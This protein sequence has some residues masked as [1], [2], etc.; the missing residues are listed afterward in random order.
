[1]EIILETLDYIQIDGHHVRQKNIDRQT[2]KKV[3]AYIDT[4]LEIIVYK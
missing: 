4:M 2:G 3:D 1:M